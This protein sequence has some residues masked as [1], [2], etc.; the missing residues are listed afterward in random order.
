MKA[1]AIIVPYG[2]ELSGVT[3][4]MG[5]ANL[6]IRNVSDEQKDVYDQTKDLSAHIENGDTLSDDKFLDKKF[7]YCVSNPPYGKKWEKESDEVRSE[8]AHGFAGRFGAG[9]PS[10]S[11]GSMLFIQ[12]MVAHM[13]TAEEGGSKGGIV[14]SASPL[15][16][17]DAGSGPSDIRRWLFQKDLVD[18]VVKLP[19]DIFFRTGIPIYGS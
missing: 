9:L 6:L 7:D 1:P 13:K 15:F 12:N 11:D 4:A 17:G 18:C 14:L 10:I 19:T 5:K 8:A 2:E 3:W 16:N